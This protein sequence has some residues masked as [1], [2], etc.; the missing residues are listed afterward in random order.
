MRRLKSFIYHCGGAANVVGVAIVVV[1]DPVIHESHVS[2]T[3]MFFGRLSNIFL[4]QSEECFFP[5][6]QTK[7]YLPFFFIFFRHNFTLVF[8][9]KK[10]KKMQLEPE[11]PDLVG[12]TTPLTPAEFKSLRSNYV[13]DDVYCCEWR[14]D[15]E[16]LH[17]G[18]DLPGNIRQTKLEW[19]QH[20][21]LH[22][23][24]DLP[25]Q[26]N[27]DGSMYWCKHGK[28][29]RANDLPSGVCADGVQHWSKNGEYHRDGD[30]PAQIYADGSQRW[31]QNGDF[32]RDGDLPAIVWHGGTR[33]WY[34]HGKPHRDNNL[35]A[36][37][38]G[39]GAMEW[40]V[41]GA[42]TGDQNNPPENAVFPGQQTKSAR[43]K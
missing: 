15:N 22:R 31:L 33:A 38:R 34:Q 41:D 11:P 12:R 25:A 6:D 1:T 43:K 32:H 36:V 13:D 14:D 5:E 27:S 23:D 17:R 7:N 35:P 28:L 16:D 37:I 4:K 21:E 20:G 2:F 18:G 24:G 9:Q 39:N 8:F 40:Y 30:M 3:C 19:V 42:K 10:N 26:V 29:H